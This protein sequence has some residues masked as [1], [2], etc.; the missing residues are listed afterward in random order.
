MKR[1]LTRGGCYS[2][3]ILNRIDLEFSG[4]YLKMASI[5]RLPLL[6]DGRYWEV[7]NRMTILTN[8]CDL[9]SGNS[10]NVNTRIIGSTRVSVPIFIHLDIFE[11]KRCLGSL[12]A[13]R[14]S[15]A[16]HIGSREGLAIFQPR[17]LD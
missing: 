3:V 11:I 12:S 16:H 7:R 8:N 14:G 2:F 6:G 9:C 17:S 15:Y 13:H 5:R 1:P 10:L 4:R